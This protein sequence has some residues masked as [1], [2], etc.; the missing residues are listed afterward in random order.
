MNSSSPEMLSP[1]CLSSGVSSYVAASGIGIKEN[2]QEEELLVR[3]E[4]G[5]MLGNVDG[6]LSRFFPP[7][8]PSVRRSISMKSVYGRTRSGPG[9]VLLGRVFGCRI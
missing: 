2:E 9:S 6:E 5:V 3:W 8:Q 1:A 7:A 4:N